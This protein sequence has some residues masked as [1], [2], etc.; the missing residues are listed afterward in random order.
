MD[1]MR[2]SILDDCF[3]D[4]IQNFIDEYGSLGGE[5]IDNW[6]KKGLKLSHPRD[7]KHLHGFYIYRYTP[8]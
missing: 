6:V 3:N 1:E 8:W 2:K 7:T 4:W 5:K